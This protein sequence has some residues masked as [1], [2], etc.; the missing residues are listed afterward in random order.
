MSAVR[1]NLSLLTPICGV[2][3]GIL[4][5][6]DNSTVL[7]P[8]LKGG[9]VNELVTEGSERKNETDTTQQCEKVT[10]VLANCVSFELKGSALNNLEQQALKSH[11]F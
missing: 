10:D 5:S 2:R 9:G 11:V 7:G 6:Y 4:R 1:G 8:N 3:G